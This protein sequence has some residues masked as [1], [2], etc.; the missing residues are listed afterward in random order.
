[1]NYAL[2]LFL[3]SFSVILLIVLIAIG[4]T[5][6]IGSTASGED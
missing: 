3:T 5:K 4:I 2:E 6:I 1:M